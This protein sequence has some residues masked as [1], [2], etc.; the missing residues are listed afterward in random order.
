[1]KLQVA[2]KAGKDSGTRK[3]L[4]LYKDKRYMAK[5]KFDFIENHNRHIR[6]KQAR[7]ASQ[8]EQ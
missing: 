6:M 2:H 3:A 1:M 8:A 5:L 4:P 7:L